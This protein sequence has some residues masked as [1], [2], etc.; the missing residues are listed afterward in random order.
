MKIFN[1]EKATDSESKYGW[2]YRQFN[3]IFSCTYDIQVAKKFMKNVLYVIEIDN[4]LLIN[5]L[6]NY[7]TF[8]FIEKFS[9]FENEKEILFLNKAVFGIEK[10]RYVK[11]DV[12]KIADKISH[13]L[14]DSNL[15]Y[16]EITIHFVS[17]G[18]NKFDHLK[19]SDSDFLNISSKNFPEYDVST[20]NDIIK[21]N[22]NSKVL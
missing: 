11:E 2:F 4:D 3:E 9:F 22:S 8:S 12:N 1:L 14:N 15:N 17:I 10:I 6:I 5:S 19:F 20:I 21:F 16:Y 13:D 7:S 18:I